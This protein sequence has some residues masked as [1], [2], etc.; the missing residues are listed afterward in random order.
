VTEAGGLIGNFTGEAD[1]MDH[2]ECVAG[3]PRVYGQLVATL[4][5]Y[6]KF[7]GVS[8]KAVV[9]QALQD[10]SAAQAGEEEIAEEGDEKTAAPEA[11]ADKPTLKA[12][13]IKA[14]SNA[15]KA[16]DASL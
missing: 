8:D 6:S 5:K 10:T 2:G 4:G 15:A 11:P 13:R 1:F 3:N 7:A 16:P 9:R 14:G 12:K